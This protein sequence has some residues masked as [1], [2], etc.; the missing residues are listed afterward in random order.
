MWVLA[1]FTSSGEPK[2]GLSPTI[3]I[4]NVE[5]DALEVTDGNM[6]EHGDGWYKY[7][8]DAYDPEEEYSIRCDGGTSLAMAD[9][10]T[11]GGNESFYDDLTLGTWNVNAADA[12]KVGSMGEV[13]NDTGERTKTIQGLVHHN[14]YIDQPVYDDDCNLVSARVRIYSDANSV[15]TDNDVIKTYLITADPDGRGKFKY[16]Q[17]TE[18]DQDV[19]LTWEDGDLFIFEDGTKFK[20]D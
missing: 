2:T 9:R 16:W 11:W 7:F 8:F 20:F 1:F 10:Y 17:Q 4:R 13:V 14:K 12:V 5:T 18:V 19:L 15:G 6:S 3:R